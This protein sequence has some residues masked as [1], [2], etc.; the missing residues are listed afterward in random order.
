MQGHGQVVGQL[1]AVLGW[2]A[3][4]GS[5]Q[6][7]QGRDWRSGMGGF[8]HRSVTSINLSGLGNRL[9]IQVRSM[10]KAAITA[11]GNSPT[12]SG[13]GSGQSANSAARCTAPANG[14]KG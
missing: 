14:S 2:Q 12:V 9:T 6:G 7:M 5:Q 1:V 8:D 3:Q 13:P 11:S 4:V 10:P